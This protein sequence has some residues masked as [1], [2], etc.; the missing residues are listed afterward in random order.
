MLDEHGY[1]TFCAANMEEDRKG[2]LTDGFLGEGRVHLYSRSYDFPCYSTCA[3]G[4]HFG[5]GGIISG[6]EGVSALPA[7]PQAL[8]VLRRALAFLLGFM[9]FAN[10]SVLGGFAVARNQ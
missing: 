6:G 1:P 5:G 4:T 7:N 2:L 10:F 3:G 8:S 9:F